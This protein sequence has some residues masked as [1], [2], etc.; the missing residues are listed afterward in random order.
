VVNIYTTKLTAHANPLAPFMFPGWDRPHVTEQHALGSGFVFGDGLIVTN[1]HV[2]QR[3]HEVRIRLF[4]RRELRASLLGSDP[5]TDIALLRVEPSEQLEAV[6]LGD[7][8]QLRVGDWV[9]AIGNPFGLSQ[10]VTVGIVSAL[11]RTIGAGP[12]DDFIQTDASIN[13]G[14][15]GG[16][17]FDMHGRVVG[18]NT[19]I[20]A[21][22]QGIGFAIPISMARPLIDQI[23]TTGRVVRA[24]LGV[25][26]QDVAPELASAL[27]LDHP[28]GAFVAN[29]LPGS[30]AA[31]AGI[32]PGDVIVELDGHAIE[33]SRNLPTMV[34][35]A[36]VGQ[37][38]SVTVIRAGARRTLQATL[39]ARQPTE[40][41]QGVAPRPRPSPGPGFPGM[42]RGS[43]PRFAPR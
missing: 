39:V 32:Q 28:H 5:A 3:A 13:P 22:G 8:D 29:V 37:R 18:I 15:S 2:V 17:L 10:T 12:F 31:E 43:A 16:P 25:V 27:G 23:R 30:P 24:Q 42:P 33:V 1:H 21:E 38:V 20:H 26:F 4:D 40:L 6:T 19:A 41:P 34:S 35:R 9:V 36:S 11:S 14:N 7:S